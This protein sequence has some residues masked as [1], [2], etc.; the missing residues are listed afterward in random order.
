MGL[1]PR[2]DP[3][4]GQNRTNSSTVSDHRQQLREGRVMYIPVVSCPLCR[5]ERHGAGFCLRCGCFVFPSA[6]RRL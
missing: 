2:N 5:T 4:S 1:K 3:R 6:C